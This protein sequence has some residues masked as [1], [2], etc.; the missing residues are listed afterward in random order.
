MTQEGRAELVHA[1]ERELHLGLDSYGAR[2]ATARGLCHEVL[3][4]RGLADAGFAAEDEHATVT[5]PNIVEESIERIAL[6]VAAAELCRAK[7][8]GRSHRQSFGSSGMGV[9]CHAA[10]RVLVQLSIGA[11]LSKRSKRYRSLQT[12]Q[13]VSQHHEIRHRER[14]SRVRRQFG[15]PVGPGR[16]ER[17]CVVVEEPDQYFADDPAAHLA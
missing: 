15:A 4:E 11:E 14:P 5:V 10:H 17:A 6:V 3:D 9:R 8:A 2:D 13:Y 7:R 16:T 12:R 1:R